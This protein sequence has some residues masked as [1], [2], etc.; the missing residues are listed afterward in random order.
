[1]RIAGSGLEPKSARALSAML[2]WH[3]TEATRRM[4][5]ELQGFGWVDSV[6]SDEKQKSIDVG[7]RLAHMAIAPESYD[8]TAREPAGGLPLWQG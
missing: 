3:D 7:Y 8:E 2:G 1:M 5:C 6:P 4:L